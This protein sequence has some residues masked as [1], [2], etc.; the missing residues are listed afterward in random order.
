M[1]ELISQ[2]RRSERLSIHLRA[3][4]IPNRPRSSGQLVIHDRKG[5]IFSQIFG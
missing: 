2:D 5:E 3:L 1:E 4:C